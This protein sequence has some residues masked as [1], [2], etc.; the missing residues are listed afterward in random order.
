[1][2]ESVTLTYKVTPNY[3]PVITLNGVPAITG[4]LAGDTYTVSY[5]ITDN[6]AIALA[7][8]PPKTVTV[9]QS[10]EEAAIIT[11]P[12]PADTYYVATGAPFALKFTAEGYTPT[13]TIDGIPYVLSTPVEGVYTVSLPSVDNNIAIAIA[14]V[15]NPVHIEITSKAGITEVSEATQDKRY[16]NTFE[17]TFK[18]ANGYH[19]PV[20]LVNNKEKVIPTKQGDTYSIS[21]AALKENK[22]IILTAVAIN[23]V[24]VSEDTWVNGSTSTENNYKSTRLAVGKGTTS[25]SYYRR[26]YLEFEIPEDVRAEGYDLASLKLV[27][28]LAANRTTA[29]KYVAR[30]VPSTLPNIQN[31]TWSGNSENRTTPHGRA[32]SSVMQAVTASPAEEE[33]VSI[34][35][36]EYILS[37]IGNHSI[38]IQLANELPA[39]SSDA[40]MYF[41]SIEGAIASGDITKAPTL[42]FKKHLKIDATGTDASKSYSDYNPNIHADIIFHSTDGGTAQLTDA[43]GV[44][45]TNGVVKVKKTFTPGLWYPMGFP[46]A[47]ASITKADGT[48]LAI[49]NGDTNSQ[50]FTESAGSTG[51]FFVKKYDGVNNKFLF[52]D[53][54]QANTGYIIQFPSGD[55][56]S[57][58]DVTFTSATVPSISSA[59][60]VGKAT[61]A[62]N[63]D[64]TLVVNPHVSNITSINNAIDYYQYNYNN[65]DQRF[66]R[67]SNISLA[68]PLKP[69]EAI[70]AIK[71]G[72]TAWRSSIGVGDGHYTG[73]QSI[74]ANDPVVETKYYTLQGLEVKLP[75]AD[76]FYV[77]KKTHESQKVA[78]SK[79]FFI[80]H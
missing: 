74:G 61:T 21:Y 77:V 1:Y 57:E 34:D 78:F 76:G 56:P 58:V 66:N 52:T 9:S 67:V 15:E 69:F 37:K 49:Y 42:V 40:T 73:L 22:N 47:I 39:E 11:F 31:M 72:N 28:Q 32:I 26:S 41:H 2:G 29:F 75:T 70:V 36:S 16:W 7:A 80:K 50:I 20:V 10:G 3:V 33:T 65:S 68:T 43:E 6:T 46:F 30:D 53:A 63:N 64:Y 4:N 24:P 13:V 79:V 8:A 38:R 54:I 17:V 59:P 35:I 55:F 18:V 51:D 44:T 27:V 19:L 25:D 23:E 62:L 45:F 12:T 14:T 60:A 48:A 5:P 71:S